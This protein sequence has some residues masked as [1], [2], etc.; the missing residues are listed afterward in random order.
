MTFVARERSC[1]AAA[2]WAREAA[3][4]CEE[5]SEVEAAAAA[6]ASEREEDCVRKIASQSEVV[7]RGGDGSFDAMVGGCAQ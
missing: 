1:V 3:A 4:K 7:V 2:R 5:A 6:A